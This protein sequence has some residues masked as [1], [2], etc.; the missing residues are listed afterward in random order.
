MALTVEEIATR[1]D[2]SV[3]LVEGG[4][5]NLIKLGLVDEIVIAKPKESK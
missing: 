5:R 2:C 1:M 4:L 3:A